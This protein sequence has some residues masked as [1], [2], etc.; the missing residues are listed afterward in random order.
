MRSERWT[1]PHSELVDECE[2]RRSLVVAE[3]DIL[4]ELLQLRCRLG[5]AALRGP[6]YPAQELDQSNEVG[7]FFRS[8]CA[9]RR[10]TGRVLAPQAATMRSIDVHG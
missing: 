7:G 3:A 10:G 4:L 8:V 9:R 6:A 2:R 5:E 1:E